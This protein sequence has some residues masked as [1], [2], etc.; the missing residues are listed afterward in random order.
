MATSEKTGWTVVNRNG[1]FIGADSITYPGRILFLHSPAI[2]RTK[3]DATEYARAR[4]N[5][6]M[7]NGRDEEECKK[8]ALIV[9]AFAI[10]ETI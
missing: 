6:W 7:E 10:V 2:F 1:Q 9:K 8:D 4:I 3:K 5:I